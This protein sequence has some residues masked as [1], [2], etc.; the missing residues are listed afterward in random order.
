[1]CIYTYL[2]RFIYIAF[3]NL[4]SGDEVYFQPLFIFIQSPFGKKIFGAF[5]RS[6]AGEEGMA[7]LVNL[8]ARG[9]PTVGRKE[10][11]NYVWLH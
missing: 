1:M 3:L 6:I 5:F 2:E 7:F 9:P 11:L 8:V 10:T 4:C